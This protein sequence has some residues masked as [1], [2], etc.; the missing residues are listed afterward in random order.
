[1]QLFIILHHH[2]I[3]CFKNFVM[4]K[5][6]KKKLK[7]KLIVLKVISESHFEYFDI[8]TYIGSMAVYGCQRL[9]GQNA[10]LSV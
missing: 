9:H 7:I 6:L 3:N 4:I 5:N 2:L 8:F 1:M 10:Y